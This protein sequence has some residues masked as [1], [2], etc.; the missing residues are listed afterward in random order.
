MTQDL[1]E[2]I[3]D[4]TIYFRLTGLCNSKCD[5]CYRDSAG[6][7]GENLKSV[8]KIIDKIKSF[9]FKKI[10]FLGGEI[11]LRSDIE[12]IFIYAKKKGLK[13]YLPSNGSLLQGKNLKIVEKYVSW[14]GLPLDGSDREK[15]LKTRDTFDQFKITINLLKY[16][17]KKPP[18]FKVKIS[19]LVSRIN[20]GDIYN[21]GKL[22]FQSK[23]LYA[24]TAWR[25]LKFLPMEKGKETRKKYFISEREF[26]LATKKSVD[27]FGK[28]FNVSFGNF[29]YLIISANARILKSK[30]NKY[31]DCGN[32]KKITKKNF[33]NLMKDGTLLKVAEN[34]AWKY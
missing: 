32:F 13:I 34:N 25:I 2:I 9:G 4:V 24:P 15:S 16:F 19:T 29:V 20:K 7:I 23:N 33:F 22:I 12:E 5:F 21:I 30:G 17:K 27:N 8:K 10:G 28:K 1:N 6:I 11:F 3:K 31:I 14:L 26:L 18:K